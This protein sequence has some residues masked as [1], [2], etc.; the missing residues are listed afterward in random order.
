MR[1]TT[2][3][4]LQYRIT[5][6]RFFIF[7]NPVEMWHFFIHFRSDSYSIIVTD[8]LRYCGTVHGKIAGYSQ[9]LKNPTRNLIFTSSRVLGF[10]KFNRAGFGLGMVSVSFAKIH[11]IKHYVMCEVHSSRGSL[12]FDHGDVLNGWL[13]NQTTVW[14]LMKR[15]FRHLTQERKT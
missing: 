7:D 6:R 1:G 3:Y 12:H 2:F 10:K 13:L 4:F 8:S 14:E 11:I 9:R 15:C 5:M